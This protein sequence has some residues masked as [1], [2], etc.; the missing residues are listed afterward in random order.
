M[1]LEADSRITYLGRVDHRSG[2]PVFGIRQ[3]DRRSH[4]YIVGKTGTGKS[5]LLRIMLEQD[6]AAGQGCALFDPHGDLL[7]EVLRGIPPHRSSEIV[8]LDVPNPEM[9]WHF[10]PFSGVA[11]ENHA[12]A[13]AGIVEVFKKIWPDDWGPR[14]EHLLR[15]VVFTLLESSGS[16]ADI[17]S[18]LTDKTFRAQ[19]VTSLRNDVVRAFWTDEFERYSFPFRAVVTAPLQ[20]KIGALLT[21]P[22]L[23][24]ILTEPG[25]SLDLR[26]ITDSRKILLVNLDKGRIGEGPATLLGSFLLSH[27]ALTGIGRSSQRAEQRQDFFVYLDEFQVFTTESLANM[28]SE[29]R[30]YRVGLVLS[31]QYLAQL[32]PAIRDAV[33]GN[34][35]TMLSF[36]VGGADAAYLAR[37]FAPRFDTTDLTSLPRYSVYVRLMIDGATSQPFSAKTLKDLSEMAIS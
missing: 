9:R 32:D 29:L 4:F 37:E 2:G 27:I 19:R 7:H 3:R 10:N 17:P 36:R 18:L 1:K 8:H 28:L 15:N 34:V 16:L 12:L 22:L 35:G 30:K 26:E 6:I 13:A 33:F 24:R 11:P 14:L 21:D 20:N 25:P 5:Q 31:H 23:R